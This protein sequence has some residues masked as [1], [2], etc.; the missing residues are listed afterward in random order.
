V[1]WG[2]GKI[3]GPALKDGTA[4]FWQKVPG[5]EENKYEALQKLLLQTGTVRVS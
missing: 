2:K 3:A 5:K 1:E 4:G